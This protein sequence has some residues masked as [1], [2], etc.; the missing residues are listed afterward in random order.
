MDILNDLTYQKD[1][2]ILTILNSD[3]MYVTKCILC[4]EEIP[5][6]SLYD[7]ESKVCERCK[8]AWLKMREN[9]ENSTKQEITNTKEKRIKELLEEMEQTE[10]GKLIAKGY[11]D[12]YL[13][14]QVSQ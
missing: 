10:E 8:Q 3:Y 1:E 9:I 11:K 13:N 6:Y 14:K 5:I 12:F 2:A 4:N 7:E